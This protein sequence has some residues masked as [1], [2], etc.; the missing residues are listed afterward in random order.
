ML[1]NPR[2]GE[3]IKEY[4]QEPFHALLIVGPKNSGKTDIL[5]SIV[6]GLT[7]TEYTAYPHKLVIDGKTEGIDQVRAIKKEFSYIFVSQNPAHSRIIIVK[8]LD[9]IS[10]ESHNAL[11]KIIEEPPAATYIIATTSNK[12]GLPATVLSRM[13][14]IEILPIDELSA[15]QYLTAKNIEADQARNIWL[16]S[17]GLA[18]KIKHYA[19][20]E[21]HSESVELAK[22]FLS[23]K[24]YSRLV[25]VNEI[26]KLEKTDQQTVINAIFD[27]LYFKLS[28][29]PESHK[30]IQKIQ[31][32]EKCQ[33]ML[34]ESVNPK[35]LWLDLSL[36]L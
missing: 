19:Q 30:I 6:R 29:T 24:M 8:S 33:K 27:I 25:M 9:E 20:Q 32:A 17:T 26:V 3:A 23:T 35:L 22:Q 4:L 7:Q 12:A 11:L 36:N 10:R 5:E 31:L 15:T 28:K 1:I 2:T 13:K 16:K 34:R 18:S 14:Q 21:S